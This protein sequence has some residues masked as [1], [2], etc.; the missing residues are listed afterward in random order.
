M[1]NTIVT[2]IFK[3]LEKDKGERNIGNFK[4]KEGKSVQN[5]KV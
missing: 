3:K 2:I 4:K 1:E 5:N